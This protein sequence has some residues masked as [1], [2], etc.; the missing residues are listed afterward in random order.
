[1]KSPSRLLQAFAGAALFLGIF[2]SGAT[3]TSPSTPALQVVATTGLLADAVREVGGSRVTVSALMGPG[4]DP[5]LYR[6][7][8][9]DVRQLARADLVVYHGLNL[10]AQ[11]VPLLARLSHKKP[12]VALAEAIPRQA[13]LVDEDHP[14]IPDPHVWMDPALWHHVVDATRD[15]LTSVDP[16]GKSH[17]AAQ[18]ARYNRAIAAMSRRTRATLHTVP[19]EKRLLITAHDAFQY[20][21]RANGYEVLAIQGISTESEASLHQ[22]NQLVQTIVQRKIGAIFVESSV[23]DQSIRALIEGAAAQGHQVVIGGELYSDA[24][25]PDGTLEGTYLGMIEHNANAIARGLRGL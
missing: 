7:T 10:E 9:S 20:F 6:Q 16:Q 3:A 8:H 18:A 14:G 17:Y 12:V 21:G 25:G 5:H 24:L 22:I 23:S 11:L 13:L 4:V 19:D 15:A 2:S 1:M